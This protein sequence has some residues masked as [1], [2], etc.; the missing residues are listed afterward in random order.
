MELPD[1]CEILSQSPGRVD[2]DQ[3]GP[4]L[5]ATPLVGEVGQAGSDRGIGKT[6][7]NLGWNAVVPKDV[8]LSLNKTR[9]NR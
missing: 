4:M 9:R 1:L 6:M 7:N 8:A 2:F 3:P 5:R